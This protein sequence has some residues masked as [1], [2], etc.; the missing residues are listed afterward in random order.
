MLRGTWVFAVFVVSTAVL[1]TLAILGETFLPGRNLC[2][3]LGQTWSKIHLRAC[4]A[5]VEYLGLERV[6]GS[7][8]CLYVSNHQSNLDVW[9][10]APVLP[11]TTRFVAKASLFRIPIFGQAIRAAGFIPIDRGDRARAIESLGAAKAWLASG[12]PILIF[13]EGTRSRKGHLLPLKK[14]PFHLA[15]AAGVPVIPIAI[16]GS[17]KLLAPG[18]MRVRTGR[19]RLSVLDP[20]RPEPGAAAA[21][22]LRSRVAEA[23]ASGLEPAERP[24]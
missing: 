5:R 21:E 6:H 18:T 7:L 24:V 20:I 9:A 2:F 8:P 11:V 4:G 22:T 10:L 12:G 1:G 15:V 23:I 3:R 16:S 19:F 17:G 14:G 13:G